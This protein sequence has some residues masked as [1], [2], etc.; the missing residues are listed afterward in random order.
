MKRLS[1]KQAKAKLMLILAMFIFGTIGIFR[2][3]IP[4]PSSVIALARGSIG[5]LFLLVWV[6][7]K[8]EKISFQAIKKNRL[9]LGLSGFFLGFNWILLFEAYQ[10]TSVA[11]ATLCYYMAPIMVIL[12]SPFLLKEHLS[13]KKMLC[14]S[15]ALVGIIFV[16]GVT[17]VGMSHLSEVK[18]ILFGLGAALFYASIML[19]NQK[20]KDISAYD[21]T[22]TQLGI[23]SIVLLPYTLMTENISEITLTPISMIM[24]IIVCVIHTGIAYALYFG[25]MGDLKAQTIALFSYIDPIVAIILSALFLKE[26]MSIM[27]AVGAVLVLGAT[28][29]SELPEKTTEQSI[30]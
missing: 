17:E 27:G 11:T 2:K 20:I 18:G 24:L 19:L 4:L 29:I 9:F 22:I 3:Y 5:M 16:S 1:Q 10:Y 8:G 25:S 30:S 6:L 28:L 7:L 23:A 15:V 12:V 21:K 14:V 13:R 26:H